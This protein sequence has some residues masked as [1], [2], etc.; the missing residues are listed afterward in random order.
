MGSTTSHHPSM[1]ASK[2]K[3]A[4]RS[5]LLQPQTYHTMAFEASFKFLQLAIQIA[6]VAKCFPVSTGSSLE[7]NLTSIPQL[8]VEV[9][10]LSSQVQGRPRLTTT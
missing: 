1:V 6:A 7:D 8:L 10:L 9:N 2:P 4:R 3:L 5:A